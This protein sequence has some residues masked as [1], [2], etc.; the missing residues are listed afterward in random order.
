[1]RVSLKADV[2]VNL[3]RRNAWLLTCNRKVRNYIRYRVTPHH[4]VIDTRRAGPV[5]M[6]ISLTRRCN[7]SC[8][9][10]IV[11]DVLNKQHWRP[12]ES[13]VGKVRRLLDHPVAQ[14]C[15]YVMLT[16]GEPL[17]NAEVVPIVSLIKSRRYLLSINTNGMLLNDL[18]DD[19]QRT[20]LDMLNVSYYEENKHV[21]ADV[22]AR[23]NHRIY[24]KLLKIIGRDDVR[25][26]ERI[27][28]VVR[29][30]RESGCPR[31]FFQGVYRHVDGLAGRR[32]LPAHREPTGHEMAPIGEEDRAAYEWIQADL[33]RRY[34]DVSMYWPAPVA[35][36][37]HPDRKRCRMPWY[38][39]VVDTE[40]NLGLCSAHASC[41]G[42][43]IFDLPRDGV[44][45]TARWR[46]TRRGLLAGDSDVPA[47]CVGCYTLN[48][49]WRWDM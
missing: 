41:V 44:M 49:P 5:F 38:L 17:L 42:P 40:G 14:R 25:H 30:A 33:T 22:L 45:N 10:C 12:Y 43:N 34:P 16:G 13:T 27:E 39:F 35:R 23:A 19:L 32:S 37:V 29:L 7:L 31:V 9:F 3:A 48:D 6:A 15:L 20:G 26:P 8:R 21:L 18:L 11:G 36:T 2:Y 24:L 28:E 1:M 47:D 46:E 4:A